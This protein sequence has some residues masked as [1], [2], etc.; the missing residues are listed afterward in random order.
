[1]TQAEETVDPNELAVTLPSGQEIR[2]WIGTSDGDGSALVQIDTEGEVHGNV[3][4]FINDN[5][6]PL[7]DENPETGEYQAMNDEEDDEDS[8]LRGEVTVL[9]IHCGKPVEW[10]NGGVISDWK[11]A[12]PDSYGHTYWYCDGANRPGGYMAE[13]PEGTPHP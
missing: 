5:D 3:R 10:I 13:A 6:D 7:L 11:H 8:L 4:V 1:M 9:C 12:E 2:V